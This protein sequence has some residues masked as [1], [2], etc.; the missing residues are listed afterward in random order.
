MPCTCY[1]YYCTTCVPTVPETRSFSSRRQ[2]HATTRGERGVYLGRFFLE[3]PRHVLVEASDGRSKALVTDGEPLHMS[4]EMK[5]SLQYSNTGR[6]T[7]SV[8]RRL[9]NF[10]ALLRGIKHP[11]PSVAWLV[12]SGS[13]EDRGEP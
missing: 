1:L 11:L 5:I 10:L 3:I 6:R 7:A 9:T 13:V 4:V 12:T 2:F 8:L